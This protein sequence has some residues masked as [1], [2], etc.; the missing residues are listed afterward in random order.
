MPGLSRRAR[1]LQG[2]ASPLVQAHFRIAD[3]PW[4]P[5]RNPGGYLNLGTAENYLLWDRIGPRLQQTP[6]LSE[7]DVHYD[8]LHGTAQTRRVIA[9]LMQQTHG[10]EINPE[11]LVL[12][13]GASAALDILAQ[14]LCE[15]G[16][17][18]LVSAPY[19]AGFEG[20]FGARAEARLIPVRAAE[21]RQL[22][23]QLDDYERALATAR[24]AGQAVRALLVCSPHNPLGISLGKDEI[25]ELI[26]F[27]HRHDLQLIFDELY[28]GSAYG[29]RPF[30]SA[31][32]LAPDDPQVHSV[33]G[34]AKD[35][36]LS[37][38]KFGVLHS[39][40]P[41]L[42][43]AAQQLA[44]L[45]PVSTGTQQQLRW[46][47]GDARWNQQTLDCNRQR[48]AAARAHLQQGLDALGLELLAS[49]A[50]VY[51]WL[52]LR[53]H[54]ER[55]DFDAELAL[56][57]RCLDLG[58]VGISPGAAFNCA[59]PGYF[60]LCYARDTAALDHGVAGLARA[61]GLG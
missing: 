42:L 14:L 37:G 23:A 13:A 18:V 19:Y 2:H 22:N 38:F 3:D 20:D 61:L 27:A 26:Q 58:K 36:G 32:A 49:D 53:R 30:V 54:L 17:G 15:P 7:H 51:V 33:Y 9:G 6:A 46:L 55:A 45:A 28:A 52:D 40:N 34:L 50:A 39:V 47:L 12:V 1:A 16:D 24:D 25:V 43:S 29:E 60:R 35:F 8:L 4:H 5:Q 57:Q 31:R 44:Q 59:V 21:P 56:F 48:L 41:E 11:Q 10:C